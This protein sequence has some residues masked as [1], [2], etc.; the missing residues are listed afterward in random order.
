MRK[1]SGT[2]LGIEG[3]GVHQICSIMWADSFWIMSH[4]KENLEQ[5]VRDLIEEASRWDLETKPASLWW[6]STSDSEEKSDVNLGTTLRCHTFPFEDTFRIL[7]CSDSF[8]ED[9]RCRRRTNAV[10]KQGFLEGHSEIQKQR[11]SMEDNVSKPGGLRP[12]S[13]C[14]WE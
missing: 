11:C 2:L 5:M 13:L 8:R 6:T 10:G 1:R 7:G 9:V 4:S 3:E 12:C 14:L